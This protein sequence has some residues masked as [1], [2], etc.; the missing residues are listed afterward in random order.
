MRFL[1][2]IVLFL[3]AALAFLAIGF[4]SRVNLFSE[5]DRTFFIANLRS[6]TEDAPPNYFPPFY[7][8]VT[9]GLNTLEEKYGPDQLENMLIQDGFKRSEPKLKAICGAGAE[10]HYTKVIIVHPVLYFLPL[11]RDDLTIAKRVGEENFCG[12]W[13]QMLV[14]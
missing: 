10:V 8:D 4:L 2:N 9:T 3:L 5:I 14:L 1:R 12:A 11:A 6:T 7:R 13:I